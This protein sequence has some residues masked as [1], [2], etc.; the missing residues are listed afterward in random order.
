M[1]HW[2]RWLHREYARVAGYFWLPCSRCNRMFGGH[3][4]GGTDWVTDARGWC[5][6]WRCPTDRTLLKTGEWRP[7]RWVYIDDQGEGA[8]KRPDRTVERREVVR[9]FRG[10]RRPA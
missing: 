10:L 8:M 6:C 7:G 3:E 9:P 4:T 1:G 2:P 5:T